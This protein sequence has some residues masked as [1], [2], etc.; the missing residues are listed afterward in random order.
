MTAQMRDLFDLF[1]LI[2]RRPSV[3]GFG[4]MPDSP[5]LSELKNLAKIT[6]FGGDGELTHPVRKALHFFS[7]FA[8]GQKNLCG[9][10]G[11]L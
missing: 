2:G 4:D 1:S 3:R 5:D 11:I 9:F 6:V 10:A 7:G 8:A